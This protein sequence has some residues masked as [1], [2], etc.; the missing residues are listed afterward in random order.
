MKSITTP[1]TLLELKETAAE[2]FVD[3]IKAVV[4]LEKKT[5]VIGTELHADAEA[6]LLEAGS[7]Q[8]NLWGINIYPNEPRE[9]WVEFD[10]MINIRPSQNNRSRTVENEEIRK[11]IVTLVNHLVS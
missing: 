2:T 10:S 1:M 3:M 4:D 9:K 6:V 8:S 11:K 5:M 7:K